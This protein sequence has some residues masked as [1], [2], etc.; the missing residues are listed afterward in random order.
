MTDLWYYRLFGEEFGPVD[1]EAL[2]ELTAN[3]TL[4]GADEVRREGETQWRPL[5]QALA[6]AATATAVATESP[7]GESADDELVWYYEF[8]G[9]EMGPTSFNELLQF[10][11]IGQLTADDQVKFGATGKWR[12][13]GAIGRLVA[14]LPYQDHAATRPHPKPEAKP[15][16]KDDLQSLIDNFER[17][18]APPQPMSPPEPPAVRYLP[19]ADEKTWYAWIGGAEYGPTDLKELNQWITSGRIG[20]TDLIRYGMMGQWAPPAT[21]VHALAQLRI[22]DAVPPAPVMPVTPPPPTRVAAPVATPPAPKPERPAPPVA[23]LPPMEAPSGPVPP[24]ASSA[25]PPK[26]KPAP[27]RASGKPFSKDDIASVLDEPAQTSPS[28]AGRSAAAEVPVDR[29]VHRE[30]PPAPPPPEPIRA[31]SSYGGGAYGGGGISSS[32]AKPAW[33]PPPKKSASGGGGGLDLGAL[34]APLKDTK[35][36]GMVGGGLLAA[37]LVGG[38]MFMPPSQGADIEKLKQLQE[39]FGKYRQ[40]QAEKADDGKWQAFSAE[41][42]KVTKPMVEELKKTASRKYPAKQALLWASRDKFPQVLASGRK[43]PTPVEKELENYLNDAARIMKVG[44]PP[45]AAPPPADTEG[46]SSE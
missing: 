32:P 38:Y 8:M 13:V 30:T 2:D 35:T 22:V 33:K 43:G 26:T 12:R 40:L 21:A 29:P 11:Q 39:L 31:T 7:A 5:D 16:P 27:Q 45:P 18:P 4:G 37:V 24:A 17:E 14:V 44:N 1:R 46:E 28:P 41:V 19:A 15:A 25:A 3:G 34:L 42:E 6:A 20:P 36:L 23:E 9:E 10:A